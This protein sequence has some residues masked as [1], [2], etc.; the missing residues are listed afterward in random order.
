VSDTAQ[1]AAEPAAEIP[2]RMVPA[3][4]AGIGAAVLGAVLWAVVTVVTHYQIGFMAVGV[5]LLVGWAVQRTGRSGAMALGILGALLACAGCV[6]GDLLSAA[7]FL[8][9]EQH[10]ALSGAVG[11]VLTN[12]SLDVRILSESFNGIQIVFYAIAIYEGYKF[13]RRPVPG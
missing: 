12:P 7:G 10:V 1:P 3:L 2:T 9:Q 11:L 4:L 13:A 8:S 5:G 6:L